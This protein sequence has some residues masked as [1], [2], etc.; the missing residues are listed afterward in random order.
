MRTKALSLCSNG[1]LYEVT[2]YSE[3]VPDLNVLLFAGSTVVKDKVLISGI[4][5]C[6]GRFSRTEI[7]NRCRLNGFV[8][9]NVWDLI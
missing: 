9:L 8:S 7:H 1:A 4:R 5:G 2:T 3:S 6:L